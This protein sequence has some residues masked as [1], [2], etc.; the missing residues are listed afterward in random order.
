MFY[1]ASWWS[2]SN[3]TGKWPTSLRPFTGDY[4][5]QNP[6]CDQM[7]QIYQLQIGTAG[8]VRG[9]S[10]CHPLHPKLQLLLQH[11]QL[12]PGW[13]NQKHWHNQCIIF[14]QKI[15]PLTRF[16]FGMPDS[17]LDNVT[18]SRD[19]LAAWGD[20]SETYEEMP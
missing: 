7:Y 1:R 11:Y 6:A 20:S 4:F 12:L 5:Y 16:D 15:Y 18:K 19:P 8:M 9:V 10:Q 17:Q 14:W 3:S 2:R 13:F